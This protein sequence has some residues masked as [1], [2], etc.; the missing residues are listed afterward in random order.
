MKKHTLLLLFGLSLLALFSC[1]RETYPDKYT[2]SCQVYT[3]D[4][5]AAQNVL[6]RMYAPVG[7]DGLIN[8]YQYTD[9]SGVANFKYTQRA[10]LVLDARKGAFGGCNYV[11]LDK[12]ES[13]SQTVYI[14]P[15]G[16]PN[17]CAN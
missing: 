10:Y 7:A 15:F 4:T 5:I 6:V 13:V 17:G 14:Q 16:T 8:Y 12:E 3:N 1:D 11:E 2:I 9:A